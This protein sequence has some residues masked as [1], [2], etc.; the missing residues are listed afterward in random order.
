M[1]R[2]FYGKAGT[3][4]SMAAMSE[5]MQAVQSR[6]GGR[7]LL[8]PEQYSHEAERELCAMCGDSMSMYAEVLSFTG[9][10]RRLTAELGG[11]AAQYL[12]KG[13]RLLC[14]ALAAEGLYSRLRV[15]SAARRRPELQSMLL[16]A[17]DELKTACIST[18]MLLEA[19]NKSEGALA[20]KLHDLALIQ[21][22]YTAIVSNGHA[23]PA[24]RLDVL[25]EQIA[26]SSFDSGTHIYIDG[27]T[28]FTA[29][30]RR[31]IE[32]L[33]IKGVDTTV[34]LGCDDLA[35]GSEVFEL[36]RITASALIAC[37][38]EHGVETQL[39]R[40][41]SVG[42]KDKELAYYA[43]KVFE[44]TSEVYPEK[45]TN[46]NIYTAGG[47]T[48]ECELAAS[49]AVSLVRE[50]GCRW[51]DIAV[52]VRGFDDYSLALESAFSHYGVPLYTARKCDLMS[53]PLP[54]LISSA[55]E[56]IDGG[57]DADDITDYMRTGLAGLDDAQCDELENYLLMWQL[58]GSAWTKNEDW[59]LNPEGYGA[60]Y[61]PEVNE[62]LHNINKLRRTVYEP[63]AE[64]AE[65]TENAQTAQGQAAALAKL[66]ERLGLAAKLEEKTRLLTEQGRGASA[67]EY[68]QLWDIIVSALEQSAAILGDTASDRASFGKLFTLMLSKYD[69]GTIP[70]ALDRV[71]AG[72]FDRIRRRNI[73][74]LIVL[75][76]CD[77]RLPR[78]EEDTGVFTGDE[79]KR[80]LEM[81]ID[82]GGVGESEL[83]REFSLIYNCISLP[84]DSL[85]FCF[86]VF[87][88][89]GKPQRP[90]YIVSRAKAMFGLEMRF[91]EADKMKINAPA[92]ALELAANALHGGGEL[93]AAS[94]R[95]F[96]E[97]EPEYMQKLRR[98]ADMSRGSLSPN[99]VRR[100]YGEK[101]YLSASR[102]DK[103]ASCR[104]AYFMQYGLK[105][106]PRRPAAFSA[107]EMGIF[108][109]YILENVA[110]DVMKSGGFGKVSDKELEKITDKHIAA[111][112]HDN[113]N[114]FRERTKRFEYLFRR[115]TKD[116]R[117]VVADMAEELRSSDFVPLSFE[118]DFGKTK[119]LA[120]LKLGEG[121]ESLVLTGIADRVD[122]WVHEDKLY[123]RVVDYK[124]GRKSFSLSDVW[125]GMG[126][127]MLLYLFS[128]GENGHRLYGREIVPA[129][130]LYIP[131]RDVIISSDE[132]MSDEEIAKKKAGE[133]KRSGLLLND[134]AVLNAMEHGDTPKFIPVTFK[135]GQAKGDSVA[136]AEQLG[137]LAGHIE[138][139]LVE[140][141][142]QLKGGSIT[143]DPYYRS[144]QAN[145]CSNCDYRDACHFADG[146]NGE[147]VRHLPNLKATKVWN[148]LS[149]GEDDG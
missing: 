112:V 130:V 91:A 2:I 57:W 84:S 51:R 148:M 136:S 27:F 49:R 138:K 107:P 141:A 89:A 74:H 127:Q 20:D 5:I 10:A 106:K 77:T 97:A 36:S 22:A 93:A 21:E 30:E 120:G 118:L 128:L 72:D 75:G 58:R 33:L 38:K 73:K 145:A 140:M 29:Q 95:Y 86:G 144:Q 81:E 41:E 126:L 54:A 71:T 90:A 39:R 17:L 103:F 110:A 149:G 146:Q 132:D 56:I 94:A 59:K 31:V 98:A 79:R 115:L 117:R 7:I 53:K 121:D 123:L 129:G 32:Q 13:G 48:A 147:S 111:Y 68:A 65:E 24:D 105:A 50:T 46:I 87:D 78:T 64:F 92:P 60:E 104:F 83:W 135:D 4:K 6:K 96:S 26:E 124:T 125:Y 100:L 42:R 114:D 108:M 116:V 76:A 9:L 99:S 133:K 14:M 134:S 101:L 137:M 43:D 66:L 37:A 109:H 82:L 40:F 143:A 102:I 55:Y 142:A 61:T 34:C 45:V 35:H 69:I 47:I 131:A 139:T 122:G 44:Y 11:A 80:L 52:A 63:L 3:G 70:A 67:Q 18:Q 28:D 19:A 15:Y 16:S 88:S 113:L 23:D 25:A 8:V 62:R 1:L 85:S 12:D 119:E